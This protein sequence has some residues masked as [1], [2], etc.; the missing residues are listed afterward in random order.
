MKIA[1]PLFILH[2]ELHGFVL[3]ASNCTFITKYHMQQGGKIEQVH[4]YLYLKLQA[5]L[6]TP[7]KVLQVFWVV[8]VWRLLSLEEHQ[9]NLLEVTAEGLYSFPDQIISFNQFLEGC[10]VL[11]ISLLFHDFYYSRL[12]T[13]S[14]GIY[15]A[16]YFSF[17]LNLHFQIGFSCLKC[18]RHLVILK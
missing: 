12:S 4:T 14:H 3:T 9:Q 17:I 7:H 5:S 11:G 10:P 8:R 1:L 16:S 18:H 6:Q 13:E 2:T 15:N